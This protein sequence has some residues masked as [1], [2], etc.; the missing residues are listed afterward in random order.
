MNAEREMF[1]CSNTQCSNTQSFD[2]IDWLL[3]KHHRLPLL[4]YISYSGQTSPGLV[5]FM[6]C[7]NNSSLSTHVSQTWYFSV[8]STDYSLS[9]SAR[10]HKPD[11]YF[12]VVSTMFLRQFS[13]SLTSRFEEEF[14]EST[15]KLGL[16][17][18]ICNRQTGRLREPSTPRIVS[19]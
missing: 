3:R 9:A 14:D 11:W 13:L 5:L 10:L 12:S 2:K 4:H 18:G 1:W 16:C 19:L 8:V 17:N 6:L 7:N 15:V